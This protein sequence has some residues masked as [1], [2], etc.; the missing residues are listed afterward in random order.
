[1]L[2]LSVARRGWSGTKREAKSKLA[3]LYDS[4][5]DRK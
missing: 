3:P 1:V 4:L 5:G 2:L